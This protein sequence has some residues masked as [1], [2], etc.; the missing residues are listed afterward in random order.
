[1]TLTQRITLALQSIGADIKLLTGKTPLAYI[2]KN[3][4]T[5]LP[6]TSVQP[7]YTDV[8][9]L[10]VTL[11]TAGL[12]VIQGTLGYQSSIVGAGIALRVTSTN[13]TFLS[14]SNEIL[15]RGN[16]GT[17][18]SWIAPIN[19]S[20]GTVISTATTAANTQF[21]I[22]ILGR[23]R[24]TAAATITFAVAASAAATITLKA[25]SVVEVRQVA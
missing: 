11:P 23:I 16:A 14:F 10:T 13:T 6:V 12:Y 21:P 7:T 15:G 5:D 20:A 3:T 9:A 4:I 22:I 17:D 19:A 25:D 8:T 24:V 18:S 1:M 2:R